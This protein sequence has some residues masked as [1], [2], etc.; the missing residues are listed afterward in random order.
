MFTASNGEFGPPIQN[1]V[2]Q[3]NLLCEYLIRMPEG[4]HIQIKFTTFQL[5]ES[6]DCEFDYIEVSHEIRK[7]LT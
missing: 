1:G 6:R 2:Y 5:E 7:S 4:S 3:R